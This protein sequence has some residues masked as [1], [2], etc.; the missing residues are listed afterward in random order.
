M[1]P[2]GILTQ[3]ESLRGKLRSVLVIGIT[4]DGQLTVLSQLS[5]LSD[6]ALAA[7]VAQ[8]LGVE[9]VRATFNANQRIVQAS[10]VLS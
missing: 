2:D 3:A 8:T 5:N 1:T 7:M 10:Q 4:A 6:T 9:S